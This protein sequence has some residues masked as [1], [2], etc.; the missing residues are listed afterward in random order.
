MKK[1]ILVA[2]IFSLGFTC[3][4]YN[5][6]IKNFTTKNLD[7]AW[8]YLSNKPSEIK[9]EFIKT[10]KTL[11]RNN[12]KKEAKWVYLRPTN[13]F[14]LETNARCIEKGFNIVRVNG[15]ERVEANYF[16]QGA[17]KNQVKL[18]KSLTRKNSL[19]SSNTESSNSF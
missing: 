2:V 13:N 7:S 1:L 14:D 8:N 19:A 4:T 9:R 11:K 10:T 18:T 17:V 12:D 6:E 15:K 5:K 16:C 3:S